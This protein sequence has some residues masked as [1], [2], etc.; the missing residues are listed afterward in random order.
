MMP[1]PMAAR[2]AVEEVVV[3]AARLATASDL[4]DYKLYTLPEPT[5]VAARQVKQVGLV[6][7]RDVPF[8]RVYGFTVSDETSG[9]PEERAPA[10]VLLRLQ[11]KTAS[12]LGLALPSGSV[13]VREP[14]PRGDLVL[15]G[16]DKLDDAP[17]GLPFE[18]KLGRAP[19]VGVQT[20]KVSDESLSGKP[21]RHRVAME[22]AVSNGKPVAVVFELRH[23]VDHEGFK[24]RS[25]SL[26]H[27]TKG[28]DPLWT[29]ALAPG[30]RETVRYT[31]DEDD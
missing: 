3:T 29:L 22:V 19:D 17:V 7:R 1:A 18:V 8:E 6:D 28:G 5:N 21:R 10:S 26:R 16:E 15:A 2:A 14:D 30:A 13:S 23:T 12:H 4:G 9:R 20:R 11:N 25:E 31:Y 24:I 27:T